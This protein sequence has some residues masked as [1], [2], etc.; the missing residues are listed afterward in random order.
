MNA[1]FSQHKATFLLYP[2]RRDVWRKNAVPIRESIV[3]LA[4]MISSFEPVYL[5]YDIPI[6][7]VINENVV[8]VKMQYNDVWIRDTGLIPVNNGGVNF[9]FNAW[10]GE[11]YSDWEKDLTVASK[12]A[13]IL[14]VP[15]SKCDLTLEGGNLATDGN[16][17]LIAIKPT[18]C[19]TNRNPQFSIQQIE[20]R[21]KK[22]LDIQN[23][24]WLPE[25]LQYDETGGHV[26]NLCAFADSHS[27][28]LAWTDDLN[29]PQYN[30]VRKVFNILS[31]A[32]NVN[33]DKFNIIKIP[34]PT[35][36][37]RS[38]DDCDGLEYNT[39]SKERLLGE[40]IQPSYINFVFVNGGVIVPQFEDKNDKKVLKIFEG[41]FLNSKVLPFAAREIVLGGGGIHCLTKNF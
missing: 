27:I 10:G 26:D 18:I 8:P 35:I 34:L 40:K 15:Y 13:E 38:E 9:L 6:T 3:N 14:K 23:I 25:G 36:F 4:N 24:I 5:G 30:I 31:S 1:D 39:N 41:F 21:L 17:T 28:F 33:G 22:I 12:M 19:G 32:K 11:L 20:E 16:G 37:T 29:N 2:S 7:Q